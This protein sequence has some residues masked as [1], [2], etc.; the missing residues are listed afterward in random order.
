MSEKQSLIGQEIE[1]TVSHIA[2]GGKGILRYDGLVVFVPYTAVGDVVRVK[3]REQKKSYAEGLLVEVLEASSGRAEPKCP[4]FGICGGCQIQHIGYEQQLAYK[5]DAVVDTLQ[6]VGK[7]TLDDFDIVGTPQQWHY[8]RHIRLTLLQQQGHYALGY[9]AAGT[10][11][12]VEVEVCPIFWELHDPIVSQLRR[13]IAQLDIAKA[14]TRAY[15][16][17]TKNGSGGLIVCFDFDGKAPSNASR[18]I[19]DMIAGVPTIVGVHIASKNYRDTFGDV[20]CSMTIEGLKFSYVATAFVQVHPEQSAALYAHL[21]ELAAPKQGDKVLDLYCGVGVISLLLAKSGAETIGVELSAD[22][23]AQAK[24]NAKNLGLSNASFFEADVS[25]ILG[26]LLKQGFDRVI[27]NPPRTGL[28]R[29]VLHALRD[30]GPRHLIYVSCMP[31]TLAR[32]LK[33]LC[34]GGYKIVSCRSYDMF[35]QTAH[36]ETLVCLERAS[37]E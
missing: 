8:R 29:R 26:R 32:D 20:G 2:F 19:Q 33:E 11:N 31:A 6:R 22:A 28:D 3:V 24:A 18:V 14:A 36:V 16:S 35:P 25:K 34:H 7:L 10:H 17:L 4:H 21:M 12:L 30:Q 9:L 27:V 37:S 5:R 15:V 13:H 23:I 1:G